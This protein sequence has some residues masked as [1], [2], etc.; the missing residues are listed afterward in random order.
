MTITARCLPGFK[1][2]SWAGLHQPVGIIDST[3]ALLKRPSNFHSS[4]AAEVGNDFPGSKVSLVHSTSINNADGGAR[5]PFSLKATRRELNYD[6]VQPVGLPQLRKLTKLASNRSEECLLITY[7]SS[8]LRQRPSPT[9]G[10]NTDLENR[11][12]G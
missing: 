4:R 2:S 12:L 8:R 10:A 6:M 1:P 5:C 7:N 11:R 9:I 3:D